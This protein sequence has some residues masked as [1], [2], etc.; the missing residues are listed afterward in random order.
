MTEIDRIMFELY[1][2]AS[3]QRAYHVVYY[4]ELD[5]H[6]KEREIARAMAG[7]HLFDGFFTESSA[8]PAKNAIVALLERLNGGEVLSEVQ[9]AER[10]Q[11]Y[12]AS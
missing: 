1:K 3:D 10:L 5:E 2:D 12:L 6:N 7:E 11:P 9:V 4:T 8:Q